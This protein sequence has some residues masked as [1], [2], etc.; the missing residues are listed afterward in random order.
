MLKFKMSLVCP[1]EDAHQPGPLPMGL[2]NLAKIL[3]GPC[4]HGGLVLGP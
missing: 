1:T 2:W 4:G 3:S